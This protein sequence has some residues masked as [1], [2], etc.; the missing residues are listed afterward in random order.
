MSISVCPIDI[1]HAPVA[2]VWSFLS[3]PSN[4]ALWW[5]AE[6]RLI[7]PQGPAQPGQKI[8]ARTEALGRRWDVH[9]LVENVD[10]PKRRI[11]LK[12]RLPFGITVNNH[13]TCTPLDDA[14]T[15]VAFG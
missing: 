9:V 15:R 14:N 8:F 7:T 3:Q 2:K 1:F 12:T 5:D 6:T 11:D 10:A 4:Y 13:I